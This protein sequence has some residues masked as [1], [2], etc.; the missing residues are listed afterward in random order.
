[1]ARTLKEF[2]QEI[3]DL[4]DEE[5]INVARRQVQILGQPVSGSDLRNLM[6]LVARVF[7]SADKNCDGYEYELYVKATGDRCTS[8]EFYDFTNG[9]SNPA[10]IQDLV[11]FCQKIADEYRYAIAIFGCCLMAHDGTLTVAEQQIF[12]RVLGY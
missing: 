6:R 4:S 8:Q 12:E 2:R 7:V 5:R 3:L 1:M 9:G 10:V 11:D